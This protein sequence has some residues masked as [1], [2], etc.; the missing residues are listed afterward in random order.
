MD[1]R[2]LTQ[3]L[4]RPS[5]RPLALYILRESTELDREQGRREPCRVPAMGPREL[6][7]AS[8]FCTEWT[9]S[10]RTTSRSPSPMPNDS[11]VNRSIP[12]TSARA[13]RP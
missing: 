9:S 11:P 4:I 2:T 3:Y 6:Y 8:A 7:S 13:S 12:R 10:T 1:A 5:W